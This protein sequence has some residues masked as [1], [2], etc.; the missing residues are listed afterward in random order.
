[1]GA[2]VS[3]AGRA[4]RPDIPSRYE[5]PMFS[6]VRMQRGWTGIWTATRAKMAPSRFLKP[7]AD[8]W[9]ESLIRAV[10]QAGQW[11]GSGCAD[12]LVL[13]APV[14]VRRFEHRVL[15]PCKRRHETHLNHLMTLTGTRAV[16]CISVPD[17][18]RELLS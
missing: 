1:M 12:G 8:L 14:A 6:T 18:Q 17:P 9:Q 10:L 11:A 4:L 5:D 15:T 16:W 3:R 13:P 7:V 2:A